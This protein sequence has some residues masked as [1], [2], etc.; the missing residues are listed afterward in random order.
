MWRRGLGSGWREPA[1]GSR[2]RESQAVDSLPH[3]PRGSHRL[4]P[5]RFV[6]GS[7][8]YSSR[9]GPGQSQEFSPCDCLLAGQRSGPLESSSVRRQ[10]TTRRCHYFHPDEPVVSCFQRLGPAAGSN[11]APA[12]RPR[13]IM[14]L[15]L[16]ARWVRRRSSERSSRG[17]F[18][19][20]S[21]RSESALSRS[22]SLLGLERR[23]F[24]TS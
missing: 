18:E 23:R 24:R 9:R 13:S 17:D 19:A 7:S 12:S 10:F 15:R 16:Q 21:A 6:K 5:K 3:Q 2:W 22:C 20:E 4:P 11:S 14:S 8:C 1:P